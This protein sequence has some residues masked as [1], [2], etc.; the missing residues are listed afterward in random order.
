MSTDL[1]SAAVG[2]TGP[3]VALKFEKEGREG[4][5]RCPRCTG[6]KTVLAFEVKNGKKTSET[7]QLACPT[8]HATGEASELDVQ[9]YKQYITRAKKSK[10]CRCDDRTIR[11]MYHEDYKNRGRNSHWRCAACGKKIAKKTMDWLYK[12]ARAAGHWP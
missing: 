1:C 4:T 8:C 3:A 2:L 9:E 7:S 10:W 12:R 5:M 11:P 6:T